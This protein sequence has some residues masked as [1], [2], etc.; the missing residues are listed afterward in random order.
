MPVLKAF[1]D[2]SYCDDWFYMV[3]AVADDETVAAMT[4]DLNDLTADLSYGFDV[5]ARAEIHG[6]D[7]MQGRSIWKGVELPLRISVAARA[8]TVIADHDVKFL[9]RGLDRTAQRAKYRKTVY[10]P[11][12]MVLTHI[13]QEVDRYAA[14]L[15]QKAVI[16]CDEIHEHDRHRAMLE[17]HR[18]KGTP[19]Y[20]ASHLRN[21]AGELQFV[22]SESERMVQA[23]DLVAYLK[24][25]IIS[26]PNATG[27]E[28][29]TR[30]QLWS[31]VNSK[32]ESDYCWV[33]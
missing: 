6:Y 5:D 7:L 4:A 8:L 2:E 10:P 9:I 21:V 11:Y 23:A 1:V 25:R 31:I 26:K 24:H 15:G 17:D 29:R 22:T 19:T 14:A 13:M 33:P 18:A 30:R 32:V 27:K 16:T 12:P 20:R 28:A 3:A